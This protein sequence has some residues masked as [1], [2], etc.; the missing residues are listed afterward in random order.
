[1]SQNEMPQSDITDDKG[2]QVY[3][4][5]NKPIGA[6]NRPLSFREQQSLYREAR[7]EEKAEAAKV[8]KAKKEAKKEVEKAEKAREKSAKGIEKG[9]TKTGKVVGKSALA[10]IKAVFGAVGRAKNIMPSGTK[11]LNWYLPGYKGD[12]IGYRDMYIGQGSLN[13]QF[14]PLGRQ[15]DGPME[16]YFGTRPIQKDAAIIY[17]QLARGVP[18][19]SLEA[20]TDLSPQRISAALKWLVRTKKLE[21]EYYEG[22]EV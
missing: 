11:H 6:F 17:D 19:E 7:L 22:A 15:L 10:P 13:Q 5:D 8:A 3:Y 14:T 9:V 12:P 21:P 4:R 18:M 1:M 20:A 16:L 2:P